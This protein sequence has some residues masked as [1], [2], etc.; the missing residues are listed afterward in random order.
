MSSRALK[1]DPKKCITSDPNSRPDL[2]ESV[3]E[4]AI[5]ALAF[6]LWQ[7]RGCPIGSDQEDWFRA[8]EELNKTKVRT[9][10]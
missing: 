6:G 3:D 4:A 7:A 5:A 1:I 9:A 8:E 10:A 2:T